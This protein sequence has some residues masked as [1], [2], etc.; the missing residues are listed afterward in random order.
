MRVFCFDYA[1]GNWD[2]WTYNVGQNMNS[3]APGPALGA[4][5]LGH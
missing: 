5:A 4:D 1:M 3:T 2:A